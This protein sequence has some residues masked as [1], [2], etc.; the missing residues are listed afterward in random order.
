[1]APQRA[2]GREVYLDYAAATPLDPRVLSA[3]EPY[4]TRCFENPSA[5]YARARA[6]RDALERAR[7]DI[8]HLIGAKPDGITFTAGATEANNL[9]FAA[10]DG[11]VV[12]DAAEHDSV[13]A[14]AEAR[15]AVVVGVG[16]D[17]RVDPEEAC[18]AI[19]PAT[20]LVSVEL[21]NGEVGAVQP[22]REIAR[23]VAAVRERRLAE[24]SRVPLW[25]HTDASQA[26]GALSCN[27]TSLGA[28]MV[29]LSAAKVYGPKQ[30][31]ALW[32]GE[33]V[34][35]RP[36]I[37]GGGQE[38]GA[39]SG[40]ES[41]AGAVGFAAALALAQGGRSEECRREEALRSRL[42][43]AL[44]AEFPGMVVS[45]PRKARHRLPGLLHVSFPGLEARR[46]VVLLERRGVSVGTGSA[47]AASRMRESHVLKAMGLSPE[48]SAGSLRITVGRPTS[49]DDIDYAAEQ[50]V[51]AVRTEMRRTG[52]TDEDMLALAGGLA[53]GRCR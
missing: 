23:G 9:A 46:L 34:R 38:G 13:L 12:T 52:V 29:T 45:G 36:L 1:M 3:M 30:V 31:G 5:P 6:A 15:D 32:V 48:V 40:T 42:E 24:G 2:A 21:A 49:T 33:G 10:T 27:V 16:A 53:V 4:L 22:V 25:L 35:L 28:D 41:V 7:A 37:L 11:G 14:C 39:R 50:I 51:A 44:A 8:A 19:G 43:G 17:G 47:C 20:Q 26:A 18:A